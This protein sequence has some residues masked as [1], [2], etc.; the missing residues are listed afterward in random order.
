MRYSIWVASGETADL[1]FFFGAGLELRGTLVE[2]LEDEAGVCWKPCL[3]GFSFDP[4]EAV[5]G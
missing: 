3:L 4:E 2:L 5:N 1:A